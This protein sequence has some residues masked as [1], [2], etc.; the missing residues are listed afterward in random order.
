M[1][2][3]FNDSKVGQMN[4]PW[5]SSNTVLTSDKQNDRFFFPASRQIRYPTAG[6]HNPEVKLW[7]AKLSNFSN[8]E[9]VELTQPAVILGRYVCG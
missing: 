8:I 2:A 4:F 7:M 3:S 6:S 1:F 5:F 9:I